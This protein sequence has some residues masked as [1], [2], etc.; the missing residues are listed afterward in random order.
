MDVYMATSG[1]KASP[2][3][4]KELQL[5]RSQYNK[6]IKLI[7]EGPHRVV[8]VTVRCGTCC[9]FLYRFD[10]IVLPLGDKTCD[11]GHCH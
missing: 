6:R 5:S 4:E 11:C 8:E 7:K 2:E 1:L 9:R 10:N 3:C